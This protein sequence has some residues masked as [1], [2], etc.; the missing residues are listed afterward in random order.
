MSD[1]LKCLWVQ[2]SA[3][4][5]QTIT[6]EDLARMLE[7]RR[8]A[9][10]NRIQRRFRS[11]VMS[12]LII[13]VFVATPVLANPRPKALLGSGALALLVGGLAALVW[14]QSRRLQS[15]NLT[16]SLKESLVSLTR[17]LDSAMRWYMTGYM[18]LMTLG[19]GVVTTLLVKRQS[20]TLAPLWIFAAIAVI[21][22][23]YQSGWSYLDRSFGR[24]AR[25]LREI[26]SELES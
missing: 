16:A 8:D 7:T 26:L 4:Q 19:V 25:E 2:E 15:V 9:V 24:Y 12:Y 23:T 20:A 6:Q 11:E 10:R 21:A 5:P 3:R 22:I 13:A 1:E 17:T 18:I 14:R